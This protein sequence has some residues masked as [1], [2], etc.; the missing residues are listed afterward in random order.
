MYPL[1]LWAAQWVWQWRAPSSTLQITTIPRSGQ[2]TWIQTRSQPSQGQAQWGTT[3]AL[4]LFR[5]NYDAPRYLAVLGDSLLV[6]EGSYNTIRAIEY[7]PAPTPAPTV[8]ALPSGE[9]H[10]SLPC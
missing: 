2:L 1:R 5:T 4:L 9:R 10:S 7:Q 8:P 6:T 3:L